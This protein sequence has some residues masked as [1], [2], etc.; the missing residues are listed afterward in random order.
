MSWLLVAGVPLLLM[1]AALALA[2]L[3]KKLAHEASM[4]TEVAAI[5]ERA[6]AVEMHTLTRA[7]MPEALEY[8]HQHQPQWMPD[9]ALAALDVRP[10]HAL[11]SFVPDRSEHT[12]P[13]RIQAHPHINPQFRATQ[14][15]NRV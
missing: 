13:T 6:D 15:V 11:P 9:P 4:P 10:R 3:E 1:L 8:L 5:L 14:H 7:S 12:L 2:R